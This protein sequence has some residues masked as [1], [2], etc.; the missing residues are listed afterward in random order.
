MSHGITLQP[1]YHDV[2]KYVLGKTCKI[3]G[4]CVILWGIIIKWSNDKLFGRI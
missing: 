2:D 4:N 3:V 1:I